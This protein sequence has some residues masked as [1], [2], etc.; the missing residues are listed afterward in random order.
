MNPEYLENTQISYNFRENKQYAL[1][2]SASHIVTQTQHMSMETDL[3]LLAF[4]TLHL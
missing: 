2:L 3:V 4:I 1:G